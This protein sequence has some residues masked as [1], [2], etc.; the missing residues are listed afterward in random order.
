MDKVMEKVERYKVLSETFL[1]KD[2]PIFIRDL[3]DDFYMGHILFVGEEKLTIQC[4]GPE[5]RKG[6]KFSLRWETI[7]KLDE[8][9]EVKL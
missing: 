5:Q 2:I 1:L 4:F 6:E 3:N 9:Q 8:Y 7:L